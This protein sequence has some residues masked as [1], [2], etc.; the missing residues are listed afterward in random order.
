MEKLNQLSPDE[1]AGLIGDL[2]VMI[3]TSTSAYAIQQQAIDRV[4]QALDEE[5]VPSIS[6]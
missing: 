2:L 5:E 3:F 1:L 6:K 4:L